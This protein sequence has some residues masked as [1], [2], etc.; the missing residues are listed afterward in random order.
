MKV[1]AL[2]TIPEIV[3]PARTVEAEVEIPDTPPTDP[4]PPLP[5]VDLT[6]EPNAVRPNE[7]A[8]LRW[9]TTGATS[10]MLTDTYDDDGPDPVALDENGEGS[11]EI[12]PAVGT[13]YTLIV[14]GPGGSASDPAEITI[15]PPEDPTEPEPTG[16]DIIID[17]INGPLVV[18]KQSYLQ[19]SALRTESLTYQG[20]AH[21]LTLT[22]GVKPV[23]T[24]LK[25]FEW[26]LK[27]TD[28]ST[29]TVIREYTASP[30]GT[31]NPPTDPPPGPDPDPPTDPGTPAPPPIPGPRPG[32]EIYSAASA[33]QLHQLSQ[34][35]VKPGDIVYVEPGTYKGSFRLQ[36][37]GTP[38]NPIRYIARGGPRSTIIDVGGELNGKPSDTFNSACFE[39]T[40][41]WVTI[42]DF[43][44][45]SSSNGPRKI[46]QAGSHHGST[47]MRGDGVYF[48]R[49]AGAPKGKGVRVAGNWIHNTR[50]GISWGNDCYPI[51]IDG[52]WIWDVGWLGSDR[53]HA[54]GTYGK[55]APQKGIPMI[56]RRNFAW[57][58]AIGLRFYGTGESQPYGG[59]LQDNV[60][61]NA[62]RNAGEQKLWF[63]MLHDL[64]VAGK[65]E[66][67]VLRNV[68]FN[69]VRLSDGRIWWDGVPFTTAA[70]VP[71]TP[72]KDFFHGEGNWIVGADHNGAAAQILK[73]KRATWK[74]NW[75]ASPDNVTGSTRQGGVIVELNSG[76]YPVLEGQNRWYG[77]RSTIRINERNEP[78]NEAILG[79]RIEAMPTDRWMKFIPHPTDPENKVCFTCVN[80]PYINSRDESPIEVPLPLFNAGA[81]VRA[82]L[83]EDA[84]GPLQLE[85]VTLGSDRKV[86]LPVTGRK[87]PDQLGTSLPA[88][89]V[90]RLS[91]APALVNVM[92]EVL[93]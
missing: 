28:G 92:F 25:R 66:A 49:F 47:L 53:S 11:M 19:W 21:K 60:C 72:M 2:V 13:T 42:E 82:T 70:H 22:Q 23:S 45:M 74:D 43:Q 26:V 65:A 84:F 34:E 38:D 79:P 71:S 86:M 14:T 37:S 58:N 52:N 59:V 56:Q 35:K 44:L 16:P 36:A 78:W 88:G 80:W 54:H 50:N 30:A 48:G 57:D 93:A 3:I 12:N 61:W 24:G 31:T 32:Q 73:Y 27:G 1:K 8:I 17:L 81:T 64:Q 6:V 7:P 39:V 15:I 5:T 46:A 51:D 90:D 41:D 4:P 89:V 18:G 68:L 10:A 85:P 62:G 77:S 63:A 75:V 20:I 29:R 9:K 83:I 67:W 55:G 91:A 40:A 76:S 33:A 87:V 69:G